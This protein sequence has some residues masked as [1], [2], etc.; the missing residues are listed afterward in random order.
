MQSHFVK[1]N[2]DIPMCVKV[3]NTHRERERERERW[4]EENGI[5]LNKY[6]QFM[7]CSLSPSTGNL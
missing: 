4:G 1:S 3:Y 7:K 5:H 2:T 6:S